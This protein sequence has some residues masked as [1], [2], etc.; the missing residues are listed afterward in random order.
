V[1][2][3]ETQWTIKPGPRKNEHVSKKHMNNQTRSKKVMSTC[4]QI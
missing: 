1:S 2:N 3:E 4:P